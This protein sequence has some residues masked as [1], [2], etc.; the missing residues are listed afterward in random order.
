MESRIQETIEHLVRYPKALVA[1]VAQEFSVS[2]PLTLE[3]SRGVPPKIG[4]A[5]I[6][7]KLTKPEEKALCRYIDRLNHLINLAVWPKF[8]TDAANAILQARSTSRYFIKRHGY[9][10]LR[11]KRDN[12]KRKESK[13]LI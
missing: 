1:K 3:S 13:D 11:Q 6:N 10:R 7:L 8:I 2:R 4:H 5:G 12:A 9:L